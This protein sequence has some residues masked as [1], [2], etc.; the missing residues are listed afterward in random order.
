MH[1]EHQPQCFLLYK[2]AKMLA[3]T[4]AGTCGP[5]AIL[6]LR[7]FRM[8]NSYTDAYYRAEFIEYKQEIE[9]VLAEKKQPQSKEE[10]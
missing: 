5:L 4:K 7:K 9:S 6:E 10:H 3:S 1:S 8:P 2:E